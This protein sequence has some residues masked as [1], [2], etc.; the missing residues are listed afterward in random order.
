MTDLVQTEKRARAG[1]EG[2]DTVLRRPDLAERDPVRFQRRR[3]LVDNLLRFGTPVLILAVWQAISSSGLVDQRF[4][5]PPSEIVVSFVELLSS[6]LVIEAASSTLQVLML[7]YLGGSLAGILLGVL[8]GSIR[9]LR[10]AIEPIISALYTVPKLAVLPLLLMVFGLGMTPKVLLVAFGVFFIVVIS[11]MSAVAGIPEGY[12]EPARSFG[13]S[14][15]QTFRHVTLPAMVPEVFTSL[16]IA[17]GTAVLLVIGIEFVQGRDGL[18]FLIWN[19]W[20][21]FLADRMYAGI[22]TVSLI[23]VALQSAVT[24]IGRRVAPW[25]PRR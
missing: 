3:V 22:V 20:Q 2:G 12:L 25:A 17:I 23:G 24:W 21:V 18:G 16:R 15:L 7:G 13:A 19:S 5:P 14:R 11:T 8:L 10:T 4:W 9:K 6:G 1:G